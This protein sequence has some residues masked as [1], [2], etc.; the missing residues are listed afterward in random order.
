[1]FVSR[2]A[3]LLFADRRETKEKKKRRENEEEKCGI[4]NTSLRG[5]SQHKQN[6][7]EDR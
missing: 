7:I 3:L 1:M 5:K 4:L 6:K 2:V